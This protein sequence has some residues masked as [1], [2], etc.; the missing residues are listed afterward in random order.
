[1]TERRLW[2]LRHSKSSWKF[3]EL[4]DHDRPLNKRGQRDCMRMS[5]YLANR[6]R[7]LDCI[8]TS[9]A[10][11]A[12]LFA[13]QLSAASSVDLK[14][15]EQLYTFSEHKLLSFIRSLDDD[16]INVAIVGHNPAITDLSN[17]L[18]GAEISNVPTSG[19]VLIQSAVKWSEFS[20]DCGQLISFEYPKSI[21]N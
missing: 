20:N 10:E 18:C 11:R 12:K 9:T 13:Q 21:F 1:M 6:A 7:E 5:D 16:L 19:L 2:L 3:P 14:M 17:K 4:A 8:F 15:S